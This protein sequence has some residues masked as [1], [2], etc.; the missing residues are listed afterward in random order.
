MAP[1]VVFPDR[2]RRVIADA[3]DGLSLANM[4]MLSGAMHD[5]WHISQICPTGMIFVPCEKGISH[6]EKENAMPSDLAAGT[7]VLAEALVAL[8]NQ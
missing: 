7:R 3:A 4:P 2:I 1:P 5:A 8:A 6:N